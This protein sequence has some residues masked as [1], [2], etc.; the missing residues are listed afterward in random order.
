MRQ[1]RRVEIATSFVRALAIVAVLC[2]G[3]T[4]A[5]LA[6]TGPGAGLA[7]IGAIVGIF[8]AIGLS[9]VGFI[10]YPIKRWKTARRERRKI[11]QQES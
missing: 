10:W 4:S 1:R 8:S 2:T 5:A 3:W 7:V 6:Y 9:I 11:K